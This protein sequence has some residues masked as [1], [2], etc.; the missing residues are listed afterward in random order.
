[1]HTYCNGTYH[2][3]S[4]DD[5]FEQW[6][7]LCP[8]EPICRSPRRGIEATAVRIPN[9]IWVDVKAERARQDAKFGVQSHDNATWKLILD[10][11]TGEVATECLQEIF[12][13]IANGHGNLR[14]ELIQVAAV[15]VAWVEHLDRSTDAS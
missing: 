15:A 7:E 12:G 10:E 1:M 11:E 2:Y 14:E 13:D 9:K 5:G 4:D 3:H 8:G 6:H